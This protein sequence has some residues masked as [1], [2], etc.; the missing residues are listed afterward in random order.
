MM[1]KYGVYNS[2]AL[3][4]DVWDGRRCLFDLAGRNDSLPP[5]NLFSLE[6]VEAYDCREAARSHN[7]VSCRG[8]PRA[9]GAGPEMC[10]RSG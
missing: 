5:S 10:L 7:A 4:G 9:G 2:A 6:A 3:V 8:T 1:L